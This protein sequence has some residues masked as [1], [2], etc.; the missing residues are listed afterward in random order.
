[1]NIICGI[2]MDA[3]FIVLLLWCSYTDIRER[4]VSNVTIALLLCLGIAH[5]VFMALV[6]S[7]WWTY[8][9]GMVLAVPLFLT[10]LKGHIGA[11]DVKL[12]LVIGLYLG[13]LNTVI[14]FTLMVPLLVILMV[15]SQIKT[16]TIK[17]AIPLAPVLAFGAIG[18]VA[19]GYLYNLFQF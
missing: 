17:G 18:A 5:T 14:A 10:W 2:L 13:L 16:N 3:F 6:G 19:L 4:I 11:G 7:T 9:A 12:V 15:R 8:P 1:M